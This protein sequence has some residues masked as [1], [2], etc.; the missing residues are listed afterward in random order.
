MTKFDSYM[1]CTSPRIGSTLLCKMLTATGVAGKP[2]SYFFGTSLEA[3]LDDLGIV[4]E[5]AADEHEILKAAFRAAHVKGRNGTDVFGLR[6]QRHSFEFFCEK[7]A[8]LHPGRL[9][10]RERFRQAFGSTLFLHLTRPDKIGQAVSYLKAQQTG[11][12]HVAPNGSELERLAPHREPRYDR[13]A[14]RACVETMS[15]YDR[16]WNDWFAR[17]GIEPLRISYDD[18]SADPIETLRHVLEQLGLD[19][20]AVDGVTPGV[21]KLADGTNREWVARYLSEQ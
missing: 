8:V 20:A 2:D 5:E 13:E 19:Q 3:W 10:D 12:W 18:L 1:I 9:T 17:E 16:D 21:R 4:P 11:L 15:A 6:M 14:I 7:L